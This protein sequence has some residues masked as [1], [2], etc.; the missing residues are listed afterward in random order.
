[1]AQGL[2]YGIRFFGEIPAVTNDVI[3][4]ET[5]KIGLKNEKQNA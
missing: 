3:T 2:Y 1:M 4:R 5:A